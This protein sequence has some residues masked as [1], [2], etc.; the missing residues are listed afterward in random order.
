M[1]PRRPTVLLIE[2]DDGT[3]DV[4]AELLSVNK[5]RVERAASAADAAALAARIRVD[6]VILDLVLPDAD[7]LVFLIDLR[8]QTVATRVHRSADDR[9]EPRVDHG[10]AAHHDE[11]AGLL[12][13]APP[14]VP[15]T[16]EVTPL[17]TSA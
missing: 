15:D 16:E 4:M 11:D 8:R 10:L 9:R 13:I 5:L 6:L 3:A 17:Q 1:S 7:G 14:R 2:D 12:A